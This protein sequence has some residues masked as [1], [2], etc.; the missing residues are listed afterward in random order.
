VPCGN[1]IAARALLRLGHLVG[2]TRYLDSAERTLRAAN[3]T[4]QQMPQA[5]A[6]LL[7]ALQG[8]LHPRT[9]VVVRYAGAAEEAAWRALPDPAGPDRFERYFI[10]E[11]ATGLPGTLAAQTHAAGGVAYICRG[12]SCLPPVRATKDLAAAFAR[13]A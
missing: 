10:P 1:G 8:F 7:R 4:M 5:C 13:D 3:S 2:D 6:S 12:T 9:H 11:P